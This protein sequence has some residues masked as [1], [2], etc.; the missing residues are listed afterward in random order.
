MQFRIFLIWILGA[1]FL[2]SC[3][4]SN[5]DQSQQ[6]QSSPLINAPS[7][8]ISNSG[9]IKITLRDQ[10]MST[11]LNE[12]KENTLF[13]FTPHIEGTMYWFSPSQVRFKPKGKLPSNTKFKGLFKLS[14]LLEDQDDIP[15]EVNTRRQNVN[16][17]FKGLRSYSTTSLEWQ[18]TQ[19]EL[20]L[21]DFISESQL[22]AFSC[23]QNG[24]DLKIRWEFSEDLL[25]Q[26][27]EID[28]IHR[29]IEP[30][31]IIFTWN[32]DQL[33]TDTHGKETL[34]IPSIN[35]FKVMGVSVQ[36][37]PE[38]F[39]LI[40]FSEG[41]S[42]KQNLIGLIS[43]SDNAAFKMVKQGQ[44]LKIFPE[45]RINGTVTLQV[46]KGV[47][48][49]MGYKLNEAYSRNISFQNIL[50]TLQGVNTGNILTSS[51]DF[52][53]A[54]KSVNLD[55]IQ[56]RILKIENHN[57]HYFFQVNEYDGSREMRR[58]GREVLNKNIALSDLQVP[59]V[60]VWN[61]Y[62]LDLSG[63]VKMDQGDLYRV[64]L[65]FEPEHS[66]FPCNEG[67]KGGIVEL[68][69]YQQKQ[70]DYFYDDGN[71][72]Y[73]G[74]F[75]Y[76][77][78]GEYSYQHQNDPC[79]R[80]YYRPRNGKEIVRNIL[81]S[82]IG[83][84]AKGTP[85]HEYT[86]AVSNIKT[87]ELIKGAEVQL[88]DLQKNVLASGKTDQNG[89]LQLKAKNRA[90]LGEVKKSGQ[91]TYLKLAE[92][93]AL[94][95]SMFNTSGKANSKGIKGYIYG[96][97]GVWRPGDTLFMT[98]ILEDQFNSLPKGHPVSFEL[99][100]AQNQSEI[101]QVQAKNESGFY[102][103]HHATSPS[104]TTG[105]WSLNV[106]VGPHSFS[107]KL[108]V[109]T[110]KPNR[111]K[112]DLSSDLDVIKASDKSA[113]LTLKA[114][115]MHGG[116]AKDLKA[117]VEMTLS[118]TSTD[119]KGYEGYVFDD[120]AK[121]FNISKKLIFDGSLDSEG[122]A[123]ILP[124]FDLNAKQCGGLIKAQFLTRV[125]EE[126]G[127]FSART[128]T[129]K[130]SPFE[131]YAGFKLPKGKGWNNAINM[132]EEMGIPLAL[133]NEKGEK[134]K[135]KVIIEVFE[136]NYR[137]WWDRNGSDNFASYV[138]NSGRYLMQSD[139]VLV[140]GKSTYYL[141]F[142]Q[143]RWGRSF[144][145]VRS[146]KSKHSS[147]KTFYTTYNNWWRDQSNSEAS[148]A[149]MLSFSGDKTDYEV[150][151]KMRF[152]IPT[153]GSGKALISLEKA[154]KI[155]NQYWLDL[156][157]TKGILEIVATHEM[158][159]N[160]YVNVSFIQPHG[161]VENDAPIRLYGVQSVNVFD[162]ATQLKPL[163]DIKSE[164]EPLS[165][166]KIKVSEKNGKGM[167]YTI[168]IVDEGLLDLTNF[169]T[170]NA[171]S[172][173]Y[174]KEA[175]KVKTWDMYKNI[176]GAI[177][178]PI[179][180]LLKVGG[181]D[182]GNESKPGNQKRFIPVV[183]F[184]GPFYLAPGKTASHDFELPNYFGRVKAMVVAGNG[185][186]Y[187]SDESSVFVRKKLMV[188]PTAPRIIG[189]GEEFSLPV[190]VFVTD[191][192]IS[193]ATV[194]V[195]GDEFF[196]ILGKAKID[197][198][199]ST[200]KEAMVYFKIRASESIGSGKIRVEVSGGGQKSFQDINLSVRVPNIRS[201]LVENDRID[202][203][204]SWKQEVKPFGLIGTRKLTLEVSKY[205]PFNLEK[206][207]DYLIQYPHGCVEQTTSSVFPQLFLAILLELD[208]QQSEQIKKNIEAGI[209]RLKGFQQ[210]SGGLS[211]WPEAY[212]EANEWGTNY[213][214][215]F[216]V[217]AK[218][219]G[220]PIPEA[221]FNNW[222][223]YQ[224]N[225]AN[226]WSG[227]YSQD[228]SSRGQRFIQ[229][230][231]LYTLALAG[232]EQLGAMNRLRSLGNLGNEAGW[233]L[234]AAYYI[235]G[236]KKVGDEIT[237]GLNLSSPEY[238]ENGYTYG[239]AMRDKAMILESLIAKKDYQQSKS[240]FT[241]ISTTMASQHWYSTQT[242]AYALLA[243]SKFIGGE[244]TGG[245]IPFEIEFAGKKS[246]YSLGKSAMQ[247]P[248][249]TDKDAKLVVS[250][251]N[252]TG[253][254]LT[255]TNSGIPLKDQMGNF[256]N[257]MDLSVHYENLKGKTISV[258]SI[259]LGL[260]FKAI[261]K[262]KHTGPNW[263]KY[264]NL[265][266]SY[267]FPAGWECRNERLENGG[268]VAVKNYDFKDIRDDRVFTYFSLNNKE[269]KQFEVTLHASFTGKYNHPAVQVEAM[270]EK[271]ISARKT[272]NHCVVY[273]P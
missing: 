128:A 268:S 2:A 97:R 147:G 161:S 199:F 67:I 63:M 14:N 52:Q 228:W 137:S 6:T 248:L 95:M 154:D 184:M 19:G 209:T 73:D 82:D 33:G 30:G 12:E 23:S 89:L 36:N 190:S 40:Q 76:T 134:I 272:M 214:G 18:K 148:G 259:P 42:P 101:K 204:H 186:A 179:S 197:L 210:S 16:V 174:A 94:S 130:V 188:L 9:E 261:I 229:A 114:E 258:D 213:A 11:G 177:K 83:V 253:L 182:E 234:A 242:S 252:A 38:Q 96:E 110:V 31:E 216:I 247:I 181:G 53:F 241:E 10:L 112:I 113:K 111:I 191:E 61:T 27:F 140:D 185:K 160:V 225:K 180:G 57:M 71:G 211:Y 34:E 196:E 145:R 260:D 263:K 74:D 5:K 193:K 117:D 233:R 72:W 231:R 121:R 273:K 189:P 243:L 136:I 171:W 212:S 164:I 13:T 50:P 131:S 227:F 17:Q 78:D 123:S 99:F 91:T 119:F 103:F 48:N 1:L 56:V 79:H 201:T 15:F 244:Q 98:F 249:S 239:S 104:A 151:E 108:P 3:G 257:G 124:K 47:K 120:P 159:P 217:E 68:N 100:N 60:N 153:S 24:K 90:F 58:F 64:Y 266:L 223:N 141:R 59:E 251:S 25:I 246:S 200:E 168:A 230:Y 116:S 152:N 69:A 8:V 4:G 138:Q 166:E 139:T 84:I 157:E 54:F 149:E 21:A 7:Q 218:L 32:K 169:K 150:G 109:E 85:N 245:S 264:Q 271:E 142:K 75:Y 22:K 172:T 237:S 51:N 102:S 173:M 198:D 49:L 39:I 163:I 88:F 87:T 220:Y 81:V 26:K 265:A 256:E 158:A 41:I 170:P 267:V 269:T 207:L 115:W 105:T 144:I 55:S 221:F 238:K 156:N 35:N 195:I 192:K 165:R 236:L 146:L 143:K 93:N 255:L 162:P 254:F 129:V 135:G 175:L 126:S 205:P 222:L 29:T 250:T 92:S 20:R 122:E 232:K 206:R 80:Y 208:K 65:S 240:L 107:K 37:N 118:S 44:N 194:K 132:D 270:Y 219:K 86:F 178:G 167:T 70:K 203:Q 45:K 155:L 46:V 176:I 202:A 133:V 66:I 62:S 235:I 187:G 215:H 106:K 125:F 127:S 28:S 224:I 43:L 183:K 262:V 77:Y 226:N